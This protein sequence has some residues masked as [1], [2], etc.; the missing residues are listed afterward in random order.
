MSL[1][2]NLGPHDGTSKADR[3]IDAM[4]GPG[5]IVVGAV[6]NSGTSRPHF[7]KTFKPNDNTASIALQ[8]KYRYSAIGGVEVWGEPGQDCRIS[9]SLVDKATNRTVISS[10]VMRMNVNAQKMIDYRTGLPTG[11]D[12][13]MLT[14]S[15][16]TGVSAVNNRPY[17][18]ID[19]V[20]KNA[21]KDQYFTTITVQATSGTVHM[22]ADDNYSQFVN[23]G[24][25]EF[26]NPD[27]EY[28]V[29]ELGGSGRQIVSVGAYVSKNQFTTLGG[30]SGSTAYNLKEMAPFTSL[31]PTIDNRVKPEVTA[32]GSTIISAY[33]RYYASFKATNMVGSAYTSQGRI[34][35]YGSMS[36]TSMSTPF[37]TGTVALWLQANPMLTPDDVREV[38]RHTALQDAYTRDTRTAG[39]GKIDALGGL[40][41]LIKNTGIDNIDVDDAESLV[42]G[43]CVLPSGVFRISFVA[44]LQSGV[45]YAVYDA[46]GRLTDTGSAREG[47]S[48][49]DVKLASGMSIIKVS[50]PGLKPMIFKALR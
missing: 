7:S 19:A 1:G 44:P 40:R 25:P 14:A 32:P 42:A 10:P 21:D 6:G 2:T 37:V 23:M 9:V 49:L 15:I 50:Q 28:S 41:Y 11:K 20:G 26:L 43:T 30:G 47:L 27:N 4:V 29:S 8:Y 5:R 18:M 16:L 39:Y 12:S 22:W 34:C 35:Y 24:N 31:G 13:L 33:N 38:I 3:A 46:M 36:G 45:T 48:E 17:A